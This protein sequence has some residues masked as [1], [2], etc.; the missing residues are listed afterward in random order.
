MPLRDVAWKD[1]ALQHLPFPAFQ[2]I[3]KPIAQHQRMIFHSTARQYRP[4]RRL[5]RGAQ[6]EPVKSV[7]RQSEQIG[8]LTHR[9]ECAA[10]EKLHRNMTGKF[11]QIE[12]NRLRCAR[13]IYHAKY[14]LALIFAQI[15]EYLAVARPQET[16]TAAAK[17]LVAA[18]HEKQ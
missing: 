12:F 5:C 16:Q 6:Q 9:R 2:H 10:A 11:R 1:I 13:E 3:G 4:W 17:G 18:A 8:Q 7:W 15:S 14:R